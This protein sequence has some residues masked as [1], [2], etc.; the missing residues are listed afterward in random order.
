MLHQ[1]HEWIIQFA[2]LGFSVSVSIFVLFVVFILL[3][4]IRT[5]SKINYAKNTLFS[6]G[7]QAFSLDCSPLKGKV[8][9][10]TGSTNGIGEQTA[11]E[12]YHMGAH[13][14]VASRTL[15][16]CQDTVSRIQKAYPRSVG[17]IEAMQLDTSDFDNVRAFA[18]KFNKNFS[19]L[20]FLINNAGIH[21]LS[22]PGAPVF[23]PTVKTISKQGFD[24]AFA[25]NYMGHWLLVDL[26]LPIM[27][28]TGAAEP[29]H[30]PARVVNIASAYHLGVNGSMLQ[31]VSYTKGSSSSS[32]MSSMPQVSLVFYICF[33]LFCL[34]R[35]V[36]S[37]SVLVYY[38]GWPGRHLHLL[39]S[40]PFLCQ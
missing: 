5:N 25:T 20:N 14:V 26:L 17:K 7:H 15:S 37:Y 6:M 31:P 22:W 3:S 30:P 11:K 13:V 39:A 40:T 35:S 9:I 1:H 16:K 32:V 36:L 38:I 29:N 4:N 28:A 12:L 8:A 2:I 34:F 24:L 18:K 33:V 23:N 10:V 27:T 21:Y 19:K